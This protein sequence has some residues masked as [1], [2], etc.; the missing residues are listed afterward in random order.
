MA[1]V[2]ATYS[3]MKA[4]VQQMCKE[5]FY[6]NQFLSCDEMM[7]EYENLPQSI[8]PKFLED[9]LLMCGAVGISKAGGDYLLC[10]YPVREPP[11]DQYGDGT[12]LKGV[13]ANGLDVGGTIGVDCCIFYNDSARAPAMDLIID[14]DQFAQIDTS[15]GINVEQARIGHIFAAPNDTIRTAV[16]NILQQVKDGNSL[17][18]TSENVMQELALPD[19]GLKLIEVTRPEKI[20]YIQYLSNFYDNLLRRHFARRGLSLRTGTKAAQQS[21]EEINGMDSISWY[22]PIN[23]LSQ[24]KKDWEIFNRIFGE[25]VIVKFSKIW[26]QEYDAYLLRTLETD[27]TAEKAIERSEQDVSLDDPADDRQDNAPAADPDENG[28]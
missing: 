18:V 11:L 5:A 7:F 10:P 20:Q 28:D 26:Q 8:N 9:Y 17:C 21:K 3:H 13:T 1:K 12:I 27:L 2:E 24:R 19:G 16:E 23:K 4:K 15:S 22:Y 25:N 6:F 14:S